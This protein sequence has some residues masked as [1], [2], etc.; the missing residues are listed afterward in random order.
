MANSKISVHAYQTGRH[1]KRYQKISF[2]SRYRGSTN[3]QAA[4]NKYGAQKFRAPQKKTQLHFTPNKTPLKETAITAERREG[5]DHTCVALRVRGVSG[6]RAAGVVGDGGAACAVREVGARLGFGGFL[7]GGLAG[8]AIGFPGSPRGESATKRKRVLPFSCVSAHCAGGVEGRRRESRERR[9]GCSATRIR[10]R[11][12][13][14][15]HPAR[16][17]KSLHAVR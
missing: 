2:S 14:A 1:R 15:H 3:E 7:S 5:G 11:K 12:W 17:E 13:G 10:L 6:R 9:V 8:C 16:E 4:Q